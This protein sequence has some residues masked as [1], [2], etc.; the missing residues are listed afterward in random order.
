VLRPL[1][2]GAHLRQQALMLLFLFGLGETLLLD[3]RFQL[4]DL[5]LARIE[6]DHTG[7]HFDILVSH[8]RS[9]SSARTRLTRAVTA[10]SDTCA[11]DEL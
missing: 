2:L 6:V 11:R 4:A 10:G 1:L 3:A 9:L 7:A 5:A 8:G